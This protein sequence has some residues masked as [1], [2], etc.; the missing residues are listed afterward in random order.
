MPNHTHAT[1]YALVLDDVIPT[2]VRQVAA[3][4]IEPLVG[5]VYSDHYDLERQPDGT[6]TSTLDLRY[7]ALND[8]EAKR[9]GE[10]AAAALGPLVTSVRI[11]RTYK[12]ST[13]TSCT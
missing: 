2:L 10:V 5:E 1:S 9:T 4:A 6:W 11:I 7:F 3:G 12:R 8:N 13:T